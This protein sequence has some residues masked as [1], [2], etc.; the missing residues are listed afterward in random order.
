MPHRAEIFR[1]VEHHR[2]RD[3]LDCGWHIAVVTGVHSCLMCWLCAC[4][5]VEPT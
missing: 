3:Y 2:V 1:Y 4:K 5:C